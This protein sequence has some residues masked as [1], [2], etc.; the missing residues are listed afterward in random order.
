MTVKRIFVRLLYASFLIA[1]N[2]NTL[3][4]LA[5]IVGGRQELTAQWAVI[6]AASNISYV[7]PL[8]LRR[9]GQ[10]KWRIQ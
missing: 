9:I 2:L 1:M 7:A 8:M 10:Y 4:S 6:V 3:T 5:G